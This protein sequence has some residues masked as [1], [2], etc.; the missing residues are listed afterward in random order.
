M[1]CIFLVFPREREKKKQIWNRALEPNESFF[2]AE[3]H[4]TK[5]KE[6]RRK[7]VDRRPDAFP[8]PPTQTISGRVEIENLSLIT[9]AGM[10]RNVKFRPVGAK[11][12]ERTEKKKILRQQQQQQQFIID[13]RIG[14]HFA[15]LQCRRRVLKES[16]D[17]RRK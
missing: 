11:S 3:T 8:S 9:R 1:S 14:I 13:P 15:P 16:C 4:A 17:R 5:K 12:N 7:T 10:F 6:G 2:I